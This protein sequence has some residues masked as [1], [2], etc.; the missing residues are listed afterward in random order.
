MLLHLP[1]LRTV[2]LSVLAQQR[3]VLGP[4]R[5]R[6]DVGAEEADW[7]V[8]DGE[9][10]SEKVMPVPAGLW[11]D[12]QMWTGVDSSRKKSAVQLRLEAQQH[13]APRTDT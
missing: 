6:V 1:A 3:Y 5:P 9:G 11:M 8:I 10:N 13:V 2:V 4:E 7:D 12:V